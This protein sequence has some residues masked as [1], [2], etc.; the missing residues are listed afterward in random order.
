MIGK[1]LW[2]SGTW[3]GKTFVEDIRSQEFS[4][5]YEFRGVR[6]TFGVTRAKLLQL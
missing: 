4:A 2:G 6:H 3:A 5:S 1:M